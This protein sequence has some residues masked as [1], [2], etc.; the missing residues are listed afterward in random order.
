MEL[1]DNLVLGFG[2]ALTP[3]N[4]AFVQLCDLAGTPRELAGDADR[5]L[6]GDGD[7]QLGPLLERFRVL[8]Y[9]GWV[10]VELMNPTLWQ[11]SAV[12]VAE[13]AYTALRRI[14]GQAQS[15]PGG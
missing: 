11:T 5:V 6:P 9:A 8:G 1:L 14:L 4:L 10:S 7:F 15:T 2:I 3:A 13:I 12:Q